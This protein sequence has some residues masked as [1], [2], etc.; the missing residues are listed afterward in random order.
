MLIDLPRAT[1]FFKKFLLKNGIKI[2]INSNIDNIK[3]GVFEL[4]DN[5]E[6]FDIEETYLVCHKK[7][8]EEKVSRRVNIY[9]KYA[10]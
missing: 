10:F 2:K 5:V 8:G 6:Q 7:E 4:G 9:L 3:D 1:T